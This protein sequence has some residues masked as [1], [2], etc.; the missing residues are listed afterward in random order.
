[1]CS[2]RCTLPMLVVVQVV[3]VMV[4]SA[5]DETRTDDA[6]LAFIRLH[7]HAV[8]SRGA[9]EVAAPSGARGVRRG[10]LA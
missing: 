9:H 5:Q 10:Y 1:M 7:V 3:G 8:L 6:C 4:Q 2:R